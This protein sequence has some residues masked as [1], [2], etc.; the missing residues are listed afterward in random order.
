MYSHADKVASSPAAAKAGAASIAQPPRDTP[1]L[2][3]LRT[4]G[5]S[6]R[7]AENKVLQAMMNSSAQV[8]H[9]QTF[10]REINADRPPLPALMRQH[11][12]DGAIVQKLPAEFKTP[13]APPTAA[14]LLV[15]ADANAIDALTT[16]AYANTMAR[17]SAAVDAIPTPLDIADFPGVTAL[18]FACM[19]ERLGGHNDTLKA[20]AVGRVIEDQV[21]NGGGLPAAAEAQVG[22]GDAIPDFVITHGAGAA[23]RRGVV[24]ITTSRQLG[25]VLEKNFHIGQFSLVWESIYP[26]IDFAALGAGAVLAPATAALVAAS[27]RERANSYIDRRLYG[28]NRSLDLLYGGV[29]QNNDVFLGRGKQ[30]SSFI[31]QLPDVGAWSGIYIG[32]TDTYIG[33]VNAMLAPQHQ[34][35]TLTHMILGAQNRYLLAGPPRW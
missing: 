34:L 7:M 2:Q 29:M 17:L 10:Q 30:L 22:V 25:H 12:I 15:I 31:S 26:S 6:R 8:R 13:V 20:A 19:C 18:N 33:H 27:K 1:A 11:A 5:S 28:I 23:Q 14:E 32:T 24:D 9:T 21:T 16:A 3:L 4:M 35:E